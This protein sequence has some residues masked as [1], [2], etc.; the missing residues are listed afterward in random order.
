MWLVEPGPLCGSDSLAGAQPTGKDGTMGSYGASVETAD[1]GTSA[2]PT[3]L[4]VEFRNARTGQRQRFVLDEFTGGHLLHLAVAGCVYNDLF[5]EAAAR[6]ITL[7]RS[8]WLRTWRR[9]LRCLLRSAWAV[10]SGWPHPLSSLPETEPVLR[11]WGV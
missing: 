1:D 3:P 10:A 11:V 9:S 4:V 6:G 8:S 5:R 7:S 2:D